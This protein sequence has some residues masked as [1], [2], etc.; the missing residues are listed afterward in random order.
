MGVTDFNRARVA[1]GNLPAGY[2]FITVL[3]A[4][5]EQNTLKHYHESR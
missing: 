1:V 4:S 3:A 2:Y 5:G